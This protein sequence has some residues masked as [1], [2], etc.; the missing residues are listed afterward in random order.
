[1]ISPIVELPFGEG[2]RWAQDGI[3]KMILGNITLSSIIAFESG[4]PI[5][6][7]TAANT[8]NIFTRTQWANTTSADPATSG[9]REDRLQ[10]GLWLNAA[11]WSAPAQYSFGTGGRTDTR[12]RTPHRNNWDFVAT[13]D[14]LFPGT[15]RGQIR[16]EVLNITNT[17]KVRGPET[18][19]GNSAF[20]NIGTQSGFMRMVQM[21]F[22]L[23]F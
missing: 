15:V 22:R 4:F 3:G 20:G 11:A 9:D 7:R 13:K 16:F 6:V 21:M 17:V 10:P 23:S 12:T 14:V 19:L 18:R 2:K 1:V 8:T 5:S